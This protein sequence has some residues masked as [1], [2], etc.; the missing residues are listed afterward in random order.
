MEEKPTFHLVP[1]VERTTH[2]IGVWI[3]SALRDLGMTQAE[4]HLAGYLTQVFR[5]SIND[6]H[7][8]FGHRRSTLTSILDRMEGRGLVRRVPHPTSR[9]S[10][11][12][13]MTDEGEIAG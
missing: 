9:R 11:M 5:C 13:E 2:A 1:A 12:V 3:E 4:A 8:I 10:V 6:L 7:H